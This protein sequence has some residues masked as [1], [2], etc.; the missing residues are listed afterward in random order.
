MPYVAVAAPSTSTTI[1]DTQERSTNQNI[2]PPKDVS[3]NSFSFDL[4]NV[5]DAIHQGVLP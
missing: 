2:A 4:K 1:I 5:S 3:S